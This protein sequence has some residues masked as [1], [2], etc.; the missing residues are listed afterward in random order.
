MM[1]AR[2]ND[3]SPQKAIGKS[4]DPNLLFAPIN[5]LWINTL[6]RVNA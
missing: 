4:D 6:A 3:F 1:F 5:Q 2:R